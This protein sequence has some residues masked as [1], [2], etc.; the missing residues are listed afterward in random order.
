MSRTQGCFL[1]K[2][3]FGGLVA[4]VLSS[5]ATA[6]TAAPTDNHSSP[7]WQAYVFMAGDMK[8]I[9]INDR[10]GTTQAVV[11]APNGKAIALKVGPDGQAEGMSPSHSAP[12]FTRVI[13]GAT[14]MVYQDSA[15]MVTATPQSD[16][17]TLFY[18]ISAA[19]C[20]TYNCGGGR[21]G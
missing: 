5:S 10:D 14:Q 2:A 11:C 15:T 20:N 12:R 17:T 1:R 7:R 13:S 6:Q 8:C 19:D 4:L 18:A 9:Q 21:G 16:G 3:I